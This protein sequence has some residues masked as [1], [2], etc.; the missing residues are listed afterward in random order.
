MIGLEA[1]VLNSSD[2]HQIG[3]KGKVVDESKNT[4]SIYVDGKL[5]RIIKKNSVFRFS[6]GKRRFVV[7]G[8]E[9]NFRP[10]ERIE[11]G[12]KFYKLRA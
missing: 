9:I 3:I 7:D 4:L 2:R 5:K 10:Y 11:R 8:E 12:L 6:V 1:E